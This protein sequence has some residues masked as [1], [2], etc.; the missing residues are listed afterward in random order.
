MS[1]LPEKV[2]GWLGTTLQWKEQAVSVKKIP[3]D[4]TILFSKI[5]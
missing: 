3:S 5:E 1:I 4:I 2:S